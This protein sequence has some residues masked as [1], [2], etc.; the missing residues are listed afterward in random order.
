M[1]LMLE[2]VYSQTSFG[3]APQTF[4][5]LSPLNLSS[6]NPTPP[7]PNITNEM[8]SAAMDDFIEPLEVVRDG[9]PAFGFFFCNVTRY[10]GEETT[11]LA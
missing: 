8:S 5:I 6:L 2:Y 10:N 11:A 4:D 7:Q 1:L 9:D 3:L